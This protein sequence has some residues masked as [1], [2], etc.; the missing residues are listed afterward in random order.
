MSILL[1][2]IVILA[3]LGDCSA[4]HQAVLTVIPTSAQD[5]L[6]LLMFLFLG[7]L[8][9]QEPVNFQ[10]SCCTIWAS[11]IRWLCGILI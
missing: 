10:T 1:L 7:I 11:D 5:S 9:C 2:V 8:P 3:T 4:H 6:F